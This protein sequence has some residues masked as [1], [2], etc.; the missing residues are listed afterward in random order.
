MVPETWNRRQPPFPNIQGHKTTRKTTTI[1]NQMTPP[2]AVKLANT[3]AANVIQPNIARIV[4][5]CRIAKL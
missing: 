4:V 5:R 3:P 1:A 2:G